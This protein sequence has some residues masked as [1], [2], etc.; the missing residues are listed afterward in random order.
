MRAAPCLLLGALLAFASGCER[1]APGPE[2]CSAFAQR[3]YLVTDD[4]P[5]AAR[6]LQQEVNELTLKCLTIPFN[7]TVITCTARTGQARA[8]L[9]RFGPRRREQP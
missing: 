3:Y 2:E 5:L 9:S 6:A 8:C 1:K 4:E 7:R